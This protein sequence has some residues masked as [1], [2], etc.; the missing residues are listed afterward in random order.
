MLVYS[1]SLGEKTGNLAVNQYQFGMLT[2][3]L[4]AALNHQ[5]VNVMQEIADRLNAVNHLN[6]IN[7]VRSPA[8]L[9]KAFDQTVL[10]QFQPN[11]EFTLFNDLMPLSRSVRINQ[12]VYEYAKSGGRMWA[13]TS[14]SGQIGAALDAVQYQYDGTMVPV[15]DTGFKFHWREP[16]LNNPDAFDIISDAQF[17]STNE[18]RRQ[19]VDYIYNGYRDAEGNYIKF[20]DKTWKGLKNDERVAMVDLGASGL[21]I[22]FTSASATAEQIRNAAIKLRDTLKLTNNQYAEQT[23]YVSSAI[24]SNL[25]RYFSDNYQSDTILQELL[26]LSGIAAI[27]EDAQLTGNQILIVPLTAGVIAPIVGQAFGTVAD[28][29]PFY[30]SDYIWRTWGAAGL[31]VKTD[32][33]SKKSVIYAHS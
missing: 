28:P 17:E 9:Y 23:W 30:N 3:E 4:N 27:K 29:R 22:D 8:D 25:E 5:G 1:K 18:V 21:N 7:A 26:K 15:H 2:M 19:Y 14:M 20:D 16:R 31:M 24:I 13:H 10:R 11:T 33:N 6:G 12:T 32:I